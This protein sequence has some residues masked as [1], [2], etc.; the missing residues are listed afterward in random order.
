LSATAAIVAI[1]GL[2]VAWCRLIPSSS[3]PLSSTAAATPPTTAFPPP[4]LVLPPLCCHHAL[5]ALLITHVAVMD[6][7]AASTPSRSDA[8][9]AAPARDP[10]VV[11]RDYCTSA[12]VTAAAMPWSPLRQLAVDPPLLLGPPPPVNSDGS[13]ATL[14]L[15]PVNPEPQ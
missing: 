6:R 7:H 5:S 3:S 4:C 2:V 8:A 13:T 12:A 11:R 10:L 15:V 9:S 1:M 14:T